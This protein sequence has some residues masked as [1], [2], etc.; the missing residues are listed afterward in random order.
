MF[1]MLHHGADQ[2]NSAAK[3][4]IAGV[5]TVIIAL[6]GAPLLGGI[7]LIIG[8]AALVR[9]VDQHSG[10]FQRNFLP[11]RNAGDT[12]IQRRMDKEAQA[13]GI[14]RQG[15][16]RAAANDDTGALFGDAADGIKGG[17][18]DLLLQRL[19]RAAAGQGEHVRIHGD[20]VKQALGA[21]VKVF[22]DL[23]A[24]AALLGCLLEDLLVIERNAKFLGQTDTHFLAAA[25]KLTSDGNDGF[26]TI[27]LLLRLS[28]H[29]PKKTD[30]FF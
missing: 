4:Q 28:P 13:V 6:N 14:V 12:D 16:I 29:A 27:A 3:A 11:L 17:K 1:L 2:L 22:D 10:L 21:L 18:I 25:A 15:I 20:G 30:A 9:L 23:L 8:R 5:Q 7:I 24:K 26:H 19:S